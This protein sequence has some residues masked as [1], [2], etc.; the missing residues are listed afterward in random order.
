VRPEEFA[1][2]S[3]SFSEPE[4]GLDIESFRV[5]Q[6]YAARLQLAKRPVSVPVGRPNS[7][8]YICIHP[9]PDWRMAVNVLET[10]DQTFQGDLPSGTR[11]SS[12]SFERPSP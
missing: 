11:V 3:T 12:R 1:S 4:A 6:D 7:Q 8:A 2:G 9:S 10:R 5:E